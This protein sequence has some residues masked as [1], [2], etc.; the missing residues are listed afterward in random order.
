MCM[1]FRHAL[2]RSRIG[3]HEKPMRLCEVDCLLF[4]KRLVMIDRDR[5]STL[6]VSI[7]KS[8]LPGIQE[9][10]ASGSVIH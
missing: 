10:Y 1:S 7:G 8:L 4:A 2:A 3:G 9:K 5:Y 6:V